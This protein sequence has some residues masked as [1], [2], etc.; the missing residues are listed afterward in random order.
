MAWDGSADGGFSNAEPWLP[1]HPDWSERNVAAQNGDPGSMLTLH[2]ELL[3]LRR[4]HPAL[5]IGSIALL[6]AEG[7]VLAYERRS[8]GEHMLVLLNLGHRSYEFVLP[9]DTGA[10]E[11]LLS[12]LGHLPD[13]AGRSVVLSPD[14]G[15]IL[16]VTG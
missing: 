10:L 14:E 5:S 11:P 2:R 3:A 4:Q 7:D 9:D 6:P 12:T 13:M 8:D 1:L 16:K 15:L